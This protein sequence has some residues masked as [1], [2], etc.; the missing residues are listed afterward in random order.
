MV[1]ILP[2]EQNTRF[3]RHELSLSKFHLYCVIS[4][5]RRYL[6]EICALLENYAEYNGNYLSSLGQKALG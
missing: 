3:N 4:G 2:L 5:F 6:D 1:N